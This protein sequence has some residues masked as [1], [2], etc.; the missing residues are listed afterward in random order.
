[1]L[2]APG[3]PPQLQAHQLTDAPIAA[4][5]THHAKDGSNKGT[6][7]AILKAT[8][9]VLAFLGRR[10]HPPLSEQGDHS[11]SGSRAPQLQNNA[12]ARRG[13]RHGDLRPPASFSKG[14][15]S[16]RQYL[17]QHRTTA[18][19]HESKL[20]SESSSHVQK[21]SSSSSS[22][23][24][25]VSV[26]TIPSVQDAAAAG[27][28][29]R[30]HPIPS[31]AIPQLEGK[32]GT[33]R[34]S[35]KKVS[36]DEKLKAREQ[37]KLVRHL[38]KSQPKH[39]SFYQHYAP[40]VDDWRNFLPGGS[41][42]AAASSRLMQDSQA[43]QL[44]KVAREASATLLSPT[45]TTT[46][47]DNNKGSLHH[48][49]QTLSASS[50]TTSQDV[51]QDALDQQ[52]SIT[53]SV[54]A[55][56]MFTSASESDFSLESPESSGHSIDKSSLLTSPRPHQKQ[57]QQQQRQ[58]PHRSATLSASR[59]SELNR[60]ASASSLSSSSSSLV[61]RPDRTRLNHG[62]HSANDADEEDGAGYSH[63]TSPTSPTNTMPSLLAA[64][65]DREWGSNLNFTSISTP[66]LLSMHEPIA[67]PLD[68]SNDGD[69]EYDDECSPS[70]IL[71]GAM[72]KRA[73]SGRMTGSTRHHNAHPKQSP[74]SSCKSSGSGYAASDYY[75]EIAAS[76]MIL[77]PRSE[78]L[79]GSEHDSDYNT[80]D[81]QEPLLPNTVAAEDVGLALPVVSATEAAP[82]SSLSAT[83]A[84][85][86][87]TPTTTTETA[88]PPQHKDGECRQQLRTATPDSIQSHAESTS[89]AST[90]IN[91]E[92]HLPAVS[93]PPCSSRNDRAEEQPGPPVPP[94]T[95]KADTTIAAPTAVRPSLTLQTLN[96]CQ[97]RSAAES[98][99]TPDPGPLT[100]YDSKPRSFR[101]TLTK[102]NSTSSLY[103]DSTMTKND[104]DETLRAVASVLYRKVLQ[105]HRMNDCRTEP[106]INSTSYI[107]T[108]RVTMTEADIFD[109]MRFIFDCGQ[110][111]GAENAII[112][113]VYLERALTNGNLS[114]HAVNWRRLLLGAL[115][116]SI[117]V[118]EDMAVF[119]ADVCSIFDGLHVQDVNALER[120]MMA[121]M[122]YNMS[123]KRSVYAAAYFQLRDVSETHSNRLYLQLARESSRLSSSPSSPLDAMPTPTCATAATTTTPWPLATVP[124]MAGGGS[125][126]RKIGA[127][128]TGAAA[129][130]V[131]A[132][133]A[134]AA[135]GVTVP[136][137][138]GY[139]KWTLKPLTV[140]EADRLEARSELYARKLMMEEQDRKD[141]GCCLDDYAT[142]MPL[143]TPE[144]L[145]HSMHTIASTVGSSL[146]SSS[147]TSTSTSGSTTMASVATT[148]GGNNKA[149]HQTVAHAAD[150][151]L[152]LS[153]SSTEHGLPLAT[154]MN[155]PCLGTSV[156][157]G[158]APTSA[159]P[160][161]TLRMKK[162]RSDFFYQNTTPAVIM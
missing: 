110:N 1:M 124:L 119:N 24:S 109:F 38:L 80:D 115:I 26:R 162:S 89:D 85:P 46:N 133:T 127:A 63:V 135:G 53:R 71:K 107:H 105:S 139:R 160:T 78:F 64:L 111:L 73:A 67:S 132:A 65:T 91:S 37:L 158:A 16:F 62:F 159:I 136:I 83:A 125:L 13:E 58:Q 52:E 116:L 33:H 42:V 49:Q 87:P 14:H 61:L 120:F 151:G 15:S 19:Q 28:L 54:T 93:Q 7:G 82:L 94:T 12:S 106:I 145:F 102:C 45:T 27:V 134:T 47:T 100:A 10:S 103:I 25:S 81:S 76:L 50:S 88:E 92:L 147:S 48:D 161:R 95:S 77:P 6:S 31:N 11:S 150:G 154:G 70:A 113:L 69:D 72:S 144:D 86:T 51:F 32:I 18:Q 30:Q 36:K 138:P 122:D 96:H 60:F 23:P 157:Q 141:M 137:G 142:M 39:S 90:L 17:S 9:K 41:V 56:T 152:S 155:G 5:S 98:G 149:H 22:L 143:A 35:D 74:A 34:Y 84:I 112:T 99:T 43:T 146:S 68:R 123:V 97:Q 114:F 108:D 156:D 44:G 57:Q 130:V 126:A 140:R 40:L 117:K 29:L 8:A 131:T 79:L 129:A 55:Q 2:R 3:S 4:Y 59:D 101:S 104:V 75:R 20:E 128:G 66:P 148:A 121:R 118:W 21:K 153:H